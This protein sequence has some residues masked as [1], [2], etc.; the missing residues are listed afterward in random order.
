MEKMDYNLHTLMDQEQKEVD[1]AKVVDDLLSKA[2]ERSQGYVL[3]MKSQAEQQRPGSLVLDQGLIDSLLSNDSYNFLVRRALDA[4][5]KVKGTQAEKSRLLER[6]KIMETFLKST[7]EDQTAIIAQVQQS[8]AHLETS[9]NE[10][11]SNIR[12]THADFARQQFADAIRI[13]MQPAS[14]SIYRPLFMAAAVGGLIG[15]AFGIGLSLVGIYLGS[16]KGVA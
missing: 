1:E 4:E 5:L 3:E 9:Y 8:L 12:M 10:L 7:G 13:S 2:Q 11:I 14:S 16:S 15:M 6:R